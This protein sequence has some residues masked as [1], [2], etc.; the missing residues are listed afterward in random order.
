MEVGTCMFLK[1]FLS[2][3]E[4]ISLNLCTQYIQTIRQPLFADSPPAEY[5]AYSDISHFRI[6]TLFEGP[7]TY[8]KRLQPNG[9]RTFQL[10]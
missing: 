5:P 7:F 3:V 9:K 1:Y 10:L 6:S 4:L 8:I 2:D